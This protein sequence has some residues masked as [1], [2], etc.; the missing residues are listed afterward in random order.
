[1]CLRSLNIKPTISFSTYRKYFFSWQS[2]LC[3]QYIDTD[4][5]GWS[6]LNNT[7]LLEWGHECFCHRTLRQACC[8]VSQ[9]K[10]ELELSSQQQSRLNEVIRAITQ[11]WGHISVL[12]PFFSLK[13]WPPLRDTSPLCQNFEWCTVTVPVLEKGCVY[14]TVH[15]ATV[16]IK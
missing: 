16:R 13:M 12:V 11:V 5:L 8:P 10:S 4:V 3:G 7:F 9:L 6:V 15:N 1:M 14:C 2:C